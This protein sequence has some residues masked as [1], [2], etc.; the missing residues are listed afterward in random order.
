MP[1]PTDLTGRR[2]GRLTVLSR[3]G[4]RLWL[5]RCDC[6]NELT[7]KQHR[8][9]YCPSY[10]ARRG[11]VDACDDC[12]AKSCVVCGAPIPASSSAVTCSTECAIERQKTHQREY[13]HRKAAD[14]LYR[15]QRNEQSKARMASKTPEE[16]SEIYKKKSAAWY[17]KHGREAINADNRA[18]HAA[19]MESDPDYVR[20]K[21][22][23]SAEW[24][25]NNPEKVRAYGRSYR[26]RKSELGA[27]RDLSD[28]AINLTEKLN[29]GN[30]D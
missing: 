4:P 13:Y 7:V 28:T 3:A 27:A 6:G 1:P 22:E 16:R 15:A 10:A 5:C 2:I 11:A 9:P 30:D 24:Q 23:K 8:L 29:D 17:A 25:K 14:P 19:R 21:R 18:Y 26:R 12:R 20:R